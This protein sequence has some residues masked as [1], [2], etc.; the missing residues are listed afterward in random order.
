MFDTQE[1]VMELN[2]ARLAQL[3]HDLE[4]YEPT[5]PNYKKIAENIEILSRV[6][7][8]HGQV[9][10]KRLDNNA[11]NDIEEQKLVIEMQKLKN[12]KARTRSEWFGR[13]FYG[14]LVTGSAYFSYNQ[15]LLK[16]PSKAWKWGH[17]KML[18]MFTKFVR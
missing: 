18:S 9:E 6:S 10:L 15:D 17:E 13:I 16:I 5:D 8:S 11:K 4:R 14:A 1:D 12:D 3:Y 2:E 7:D